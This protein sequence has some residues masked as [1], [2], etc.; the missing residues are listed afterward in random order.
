MFKQ[1][2]PELACIDIGIADNNINPVRSTAFLTAFLINAFHAGR[3]V[4]PT[5]QTFNQFFV[6][7]VKIVEFHAHNL[8]PQWKMHPDMCKHA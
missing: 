3:R 2:K 6:K 5:G 1:N 7:N 4:Q 8:E